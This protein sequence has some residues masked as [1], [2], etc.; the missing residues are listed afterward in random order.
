MIGFVIFVAIMVPETKNKTF[1]EIASEWQK[2]ENIEV[3]EVVDDPIYTSNNFS[4]AELHNIRDLTAT[5]DN[6]RD[7]KW[8]VG[9]GLAAVFSPDITLKMPNE[10]SPAD[11]VNASK[12]DD[13]EKI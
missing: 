1:E 6:E 9:D 11:S 3:E 8:A 5:Q 4:D 7:D 13:E 12:A 2:G 10:K